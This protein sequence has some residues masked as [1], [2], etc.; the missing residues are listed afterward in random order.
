MLA[1]LAGCAGD[2]L[3]PGQ[4]AAQRAEQ[5]RLTYAGPWSDAT[6]G[7]RCRMRLA[8]NQVRETER[9]RCAL[10][11]WNDS[12]TS[13]EINNTN[14]SKFA[15]ATS[16]AIE[17]EM[18]FS[19]S[20]DARN[21]PEKPVRLAPGEKLL[22]GPALLRVTPAVAPRIGAQHLTA[23]TLI[24]TQRVIAPPAMISVTPAQWGSTLNGLRICIGTDSP[25]V[26]AD[27]AMTVF[28]YVH[29]TTNGRVTILS[30]DWARPRIRSE[31]D[32]LT[33]ILTSAW[34]APTASLPPRTIQ[35][36]ELLPGSLFDRPGVYRLRVILDA[37][38]LS[39]VPKGI[40][41]GSLVSNELTVQV[42]AG[43]KPAVS[44]S[45]PSTAPAG[46]K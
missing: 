45:S 14:A 12:G 28:L 5:R 19:E 22:I 16:F 7:I 8:T 2:G 6:R 42:S 38:P 29:N 9:L 20:L 44:S 15:R 25:S 30:P 32:L 36:R 24:A 43:E 41:T 26:G 46:G 31:D 11:L 18:Y 13:V 35:R 4:Q 17:N 40:W 34:G 10:E 39:F 27:E 33:V 1:T 3:S 37:P 23:S 21:L